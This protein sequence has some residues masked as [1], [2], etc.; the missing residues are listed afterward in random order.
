MCLSQ[1]QHHIY[2]KCKLANYEPEASNEPRAERPPEQEQGGNRTPAIPGGFPNFLLPDSLRSRNKNGGGEDED[3]EVGDRPPRQAAQAAHA[4]DTYKHHLVTETLV[5]SCAEA[6]NNASLRELPEEERHCPSERWQPLG[7]AHDYAATT[8]ANDDCPVCVAIEVAG[9]EAMS[10][11]RVI[12]VGPRPDNN[13]QQQS[14]RDAHDNAEHLKPDQHR[15]HRRVSHPK[16]LSH[17]VIM[18]RD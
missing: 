14:S 3:V 2:H 7:N 18:R 1:I 17:A 11:K 9:R 4:E 13:A 8:N 12:H 15:P 16:Y 5:V 6:Q 10:T